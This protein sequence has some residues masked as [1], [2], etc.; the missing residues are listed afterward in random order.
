VLALLEVFLQRVV[1]LDEVALSHDVDG[2]VRSPFS[3]DPLVAFI[4][5]NFLILVKISQLIAEV[6]S[7]NVN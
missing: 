6:S 4:L 3:T 2:L 7:E 5:L 1:R